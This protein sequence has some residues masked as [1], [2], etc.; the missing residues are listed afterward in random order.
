MSRVS[1]ADGDPMTRPRPLLTQAQQKRIAPA[2][3]PQG[4]PPVNRQPQCVGRASVD[5]AER[6]TRSGSGGEISTPLDGLAAGLPGGARRAAEHP[7]HFSQRVER[8]PAIA[9]EGVVSG[10]EFRSREKGGAEVGE[11][12][13]GKGTKWMVVV[14]GVVVPLGDHLRSASLAE[15]RLAEPTLAAIRVGRR[16]RAG[17]LRKNP[18]RVIA[19]KIYDSD[20]LR[21]RL[22]RRG[23]KLVCTHKK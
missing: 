1:S 22:R 8:A 4:W 14:D 18:E 23:I 15:V 20:P 12:Q 11:N 3:A 17:R 21:K 19:D 16:H 9:V 5:S 10:R 6:P 13:A 2:R 7:A